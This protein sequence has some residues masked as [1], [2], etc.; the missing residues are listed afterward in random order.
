MSLSTDVASDARKLNSLEDA[1]G[2]ARVSKRDAEG[3]DERAVGAT[4]FRFLSHND[5]YEAYHQLRKWVVHQPRTSDQLKSKVV[6]RIK[7][8]QEKIVKLKEELNTVPEVIKVPP[9]VEQANGT[10]NSLRDVFAKAESGIPTDSDIRNAKKLV[11]SIQDM[12]KKFVTKPE[13]K[14]TESAK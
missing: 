8:Y 5:C 4:M 10:L 9:E 7:S 12:V 6:A 1:S 3:A 14:K 11:A 13:E 2:W